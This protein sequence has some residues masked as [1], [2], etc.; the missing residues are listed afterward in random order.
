ML[1]FNFSCSVARN[2]NPTPSQNRIHR[3]RI[4]LKCKQNGAMLSFRQTCCGVKLSKLL[5]SAGRSAPRRGVGGALAYKSLACLKT[6][7]VAFARS[8][9]QRGT[10]NLFTSV[11]FFRNATPVAFQVSSLRYN[12]NHVSWHRKIIHDLS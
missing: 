3:F 5:L 12:R 11:T 8:Y 7:V 10:S 2:R 9:R 6:F 4:S 1:L